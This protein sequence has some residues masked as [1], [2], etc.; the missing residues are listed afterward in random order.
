LCPAG[1]ISDV[2]KNCVKAAPNIDCEGTVGGTKVFDSCGVCGGDGQ[3]CNVK[4]IYF[5]WGSSSCPAPSKKLY[6]GFTA[7]PYYSHG[8]SGYNY[9][10]LQK[11]PTFGYEQSDYSQ[12][13]GELFGVQYATSSGG[14]QELKNVNGATVPCAACE[15]PRSGVFMYPGSTTCPQGWHQEYQGYLMANYY[16]GSYYRTEFICVERLAERGS[17]PSY[18]GQSYLFPTE[19]QCSGLP[20]PPYTQNRELACVV[21]SPEQS[22]GSG[23]V[24]IRW[25]KDTCPSNS[26]TIKLYNGRTAV[27]NTGHSGGGAN[28]VCLPMQPSY[29]QHN[30]RQQ[31]GAFIYGAYYYTSSGPAYAQGLRAVHNRRI[32][33]SVCFTPDAHTH[34]MVPGRYTCPANFNAE[35]Y[36]YLF[37]SYYG[38]YPVNYIC[39]D[40]EPSSIGTESGGGANLYTVEIE[41]GSLQCE[42]NLGGYVGNREA[43]CVVCTPDTKRKTAAYVRWGS[44]TCPGTNSTTR[45]VY[46]GFLA[47]KYHNHVGSGANLLCMHPAAQYLNHSDSDHSSGRLYGYEYQNGGLRGPFYQVYDRE[48]PC[49]VCENVQAATTFT[50]FGSDVCPTGY[51][52]DYIG[53]VMSSHAGHY[54]TEFIC[55]DRNPGFYNNGRGRSNDN[56]GILYPTESQCGAIPC[57][58]YTNNREVMCAQ[59]SRLTRNCAYFWHGQTCV[60]TC[61]EDTYIDSNKVCQQ[62][63][64][65]CAKGCTGPT[66]V[67][68]TSCQH[69]AM[70]RSGECVV[71]CPKG[72]VSDVTNVCVKSTSFTDCAGVVNGTA[73]IDRC[74]VCGGDNSSCNL[75]AIYV[76]WGRTVCPSTAKLL[77]YG[78]AA[79]ALDDHSGSGYNTLCLPNKPGYSW[80]HTDYTSS[81]SYLYGIE[82]ETSGFGVADLY[83]VANSPVQCAV[84]EAARG[85]TVMIPGTYKCPTNWTAE[86]TGY[87]M[88]NQYNRYKGEFVC[89]DQHPERV[90][91]RNNYNQ[92]AWYPTEFQ[93]GTLPCPPYNNDRE[94]T[95]AVCSPASDSQTGTVYTRW[96]R[97]VCPSDNA[98]VYQGRAA[99]S[100]Q[101]GSGANP[102]CVTPSPL[103]LTHSDSNNAGAQLYGAQ[104]QWNSQVEAFR[105]VNSKRIPCTVCMIANKGS[106][107]MVSGENFCP[108]E[109][110]LEYWGY[111]MAAY[112]SHQKSNWVCVDSKPEALDLPVSGSGQTQWYPTE[113]QC[114]SIQC[115][116][117]RPNGYVQDRELTCAVCS[118]AT[119][120]RTVVY[121]RYGRSVCPAGS[122]L[123]RRGFVAGS[124]YSYTGSGANLL[125]MTPNTTYADHNDNNQEGALLYGYE[126]ET[127]S[128]ALRS[129]AYRSVHNYEIPC[130]VCE[131]VGSSATFTMYGNNT[132]PSGYSSDYVGYAFSNY[133]SSYH[134]KGQYVCVDNQ[135]ERYA[136]TLGGGNHNQGRLY[137]ASLQCGTLP[138]P[139]YSSNREVIC[140]QCSKVVG[141]CDG[142]WNGQECVSECPPNKYSDN[143]KRCLACHDQCGSGG[144][145]GPAPTQC[146]DCLSYNMSGECVNECPNGTVANPQ[147]V[148][149]NKTSELDCSGVAGGSKTVDRCGVCGGDGTSCNTRAVYTR[150]G[151]KSCPSGTRKLYEGYSASAYHGSSGSGYNRLCLPRD[152]GFGFQHYDSDSDTAEIYGS[153]YETG[154]APSAQSRTVSSSP[155]PCAV[156]EAV[157]G[158]VLQVSGSTQ[159]PTGWSREYY[160]YVMANYY[161]NY[162]GEYVCVDVAME[163][164]DGNYNQNQDRWYIAETYCEGISCPPHVQ[165]REITCAVCIPPA[166]ES[167]A[168]YYRWGR[169]DCP[170]G[171]KLLYPGQAVSSRYSHSGSGA[172]PMCLTD[173]P[174]WTGLQTSDS[175]QNGARMSGARYQISGGLRVLGSKING[176]SVPCSACYVTDKETYIMAPGSDVCPDGWK[177]EYKGYL[178]AG[179]YSYTKNDWVCVDQEAQAGSAPSNGH[180]YWYATEVRCG[181]LPCYTSQQDAY[182][183]YREVT[184]ALCTPD[185]KR[186]SSVFVRWG[187]PDCPKTSVKVYDGLVGGAYHTHSGSG[188]SVLCLRQNATYGDRNDNNQYGALLYG[189]EYHSS[190][191]SSSDYSSMQD[192]EMSCAVCESRGISSTFTLFGKDVCPE[193]YVADYTGYGFASRH[194]SSYRKTNYFCLDSKP[195][196]YS[197]RTGWNYNHGIVWPM[198]ASCGTLPC[199]P[200]TQNREMLC[201]QCT[202]QS[203]VCP[204]Y[205]DGQ[206]CVIDCGINKYPDSSKRC[207]L[208]DSECIGCNGTGSSQCIQCSHYKYKGQCVL[209]CPKGT[210]ANSTN[211]CFVAQPNADCAGVPNGGKTLDRCGVCGG[212]GSSCARKA[213]F[214]RWGRQTCPPNSTKIYD[215]YMG[216]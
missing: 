22:T 121:T 53:Y 47:G 57:P 28:T 136:N 6:D 89:V 208:C 52:A 86:Y 169:K 102:I 181:S 122:K 16:H 159:C 95:C 166:N 115:S 74:G 43:T 179:Y 25:G 12:S 111:L 8:G 9:V 56:Q 202:Y 50:Q 191:L 118:P 206:D 97:T 82:F 214:T 39:V 163:K 199:P 38:N 26:T 71:E 140:T 68:C 40:H 62:C 215:G 124:Y 45:Q 175:Q 207:R 182:V 80:E 216:M 73:V 193:G 14:I 155:I 168:V 17:G 87:V 130:A 94:L 212:N 201:A 195:Q 176:R 23:S 112:Y 69:Y 150:W 66:A 157:R 113:V 160:G 72:Y 1:Y 146:A 88:S 105:V 84:C 114:G 10:C 139:P 165:Y 135:P 171:A 31:Y 149:V 100:P 128:G 210:I 143:E 209:N 11:K 205:L 123:V 91:V 46:S 24:Y 188:A 107:I 132:C 110:N 138:C 173:T 90:T 129:Q 99:S 158:S 13:A 2:N 44:T 196:E 204:H 83:S 63:H 186:K 144:C 119:S 37:A 18:R 85:E 125:C 15:A 70:E 106:H 21:C 120:R 134:R 142:F 184:C 98:L 35:Y 141:L 67:N 4:A 172:N 36:G 185:T 3:S 187:R 133:H 20:C 109:W 174:S 170:T 48:V 126:Y 19:V 161:S 103:Y 75:K 64:P 117:S 79:S 213:I 131:N 30:D 164:G 156:C 183:Q 33:C 151:R 101:S 154:S 81:G 197:R 148:C 92:D 65:E 178:L 104:Y 147:N 55:I 96:G 162:K 194:G 32:P 200:Y 116:R 49:T 58:P 152:P 137:P 27:S 203:T 42:N 60:T 29:L 51:S 145:T 198:E 167:G 76:R 180:A 54:K 177:L 34:V 61:P 127:G 7:S 77:Y 189:V 5:H 78:V 41:C 93:C 153:E 190:G 211:D 108:S 192:R 59:C